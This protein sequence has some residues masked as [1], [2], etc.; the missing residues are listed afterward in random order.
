MVAAENDIQIFDRALMKQKRTRAAA[1]FD[2]TDFLFTWTIDNLRD[3]LDIIQR[4]PETIVQ[5]G[6]RGGRIV[7]GAA[8]CDL[9]TAFAP[10]ILADEEFLPFTPASLDCIISALNLH[11]VNDLP[12]SLL[13]I[14]NTLKPDGMF[15]AALFGGET[16]HE[17]RASL[18]AAEMDLKGGMSPR[19]FPFADKQELGALLQRAGFALPVVDSEIITV[20]Y[21]NMF[22]LLADIRGMGESNIIAARDKRYVGKDFFLKA[23][24]HYAENFADNHEGADGRIV[25]SFEIIFLI[26]WAPHESQQKPLQ[27][28]SAKE[29]LAD[30]LNAK[31]TVL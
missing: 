4:S 17:L 7:D 14:K 13:Q 10:T 28:G 12:G 6:A 1:S 23:A 9:N 29:R 27:P 8:V 11:S 3:R 30:V 16:L 18:N 19:V 25:A 31:E 24:Q 5:L 21:D 15:V 26:G 20:T 2:K 22:K